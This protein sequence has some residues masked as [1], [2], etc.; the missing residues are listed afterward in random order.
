MSP[1]I[2]KTQEEY[3]DN[4][5]Q[6]L[7]HKSSNILLDSDYYN[8]YEEGIQLGHASIYAAIV[9]KHIANGTSEHSAKNFA[10]S[11]IEGFSSSIQNHQKGDCY[12]QNYA[13]ASTDFMFT[14]EEKTTSGHIFEQMSASVDYTE[15]SIF[16]DDDEE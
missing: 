15:D 11:Y 10:Q 7:E 2:T 6:P 3:I 1:D 9:A 16:N 12:A 5:I 8:A 4:I 13:E 14:E